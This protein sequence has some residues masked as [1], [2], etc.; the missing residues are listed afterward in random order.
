MKLH[1]RIIMLILV[2]ISLFLLKNTVCATE[3]TQKLYQDIKI[4][5]D[6]SITVKEAAV[7]SGE[8]NGRRRNIEFRNKYANKFS[9]IYSNFTGN[10]DIY[11]GSEIIN[12]KIGDISEENFKTIDDI[13]KI[14]KMYTEVTS[15]SSGAYGKYELTISDYGAN[16]KVYCPSTRN[17]VFYMEY[18]IKNA[19][20]V[21]NDIAE[22]YWNVMGSGYEEIIADFQVL[23]HLPEEDKDVRIWTHGPLSG[24]NA[25]VDKKTLNFKDRNVDPYQA[26]TV[27]IMFNKK[28]VPLATKKSGVN[29]KENI[30]K[31]EASQADQANAQREKNKLEKINTASSYV[32][33]LKESPSM[34]AYNRALENVKNLPS[35]IDEKDDLLN[36]IY[37]LK[38]VV[39]TK[40][41]NSI[42]SRISYLDINDSYST[43]SRDIK[44]IEKEIGYGFDEEYKKNYN[45]QLETY[46]NELTRKEKKIRTA[47]TFGAIMLGIIGI[48]ICGKDLIKKIKYKNAFGQKYYRDFPTDDAPYV[49][50]Y[51]IKGKITNLS[52]SAT[53]L[54]LI[55]RNIIK[56]EEVLN[57]K[58]KKDV[59]LILV[60]EN[61]SG[62]NA[63]NEILKLLFKKVGKSGKCN[64]N[65]LKNY[66]KKSESKARSII[67]SIDNFRDETIKESKSKEYFEKSKGKVLKIFYLIIMFIYM[68][69][70]TPSVSLG[71]ANSGR[72]NII[73]V[74]IC[75]FIFI[76]LLFITLTFKKRTPN[77]ALEYS[78]WMAHKR[79]LKDFSK[80]DEKE[81]PEVKLWEKY[82]VTATVLGCADKVQEAMKLKIANINEYD[83]NLF[84]DMYLISNMNHNLTRTI[85]R[86]V[87][88]SI[89]TA[90]STI[91]AESSSSSSG[92][93]GG[94]SSFGGG[95]GGR[96]RWRRPFLS[97]LFTNF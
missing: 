75:L 58:N 96:W 19:V 14:E 2:V 57:S 39:N 21:H 91:Y 4:N 55:A 17:K 64:L 40:W 16:F 9:G 1:K 87:N 15:A 42:E 94:G 82:M 29:G 47:S 6:G 36:E 89:S 86:A 60:V 97:L 63:E 35:N 83:D 62:T 3:T 7:L 46:K 32:I 31:Y 10:T 8:Y 76:T 66:G 38:D 81:L 79:F 18:T 54:D 37:K 85:N 92:G 78:K 34:Y 41:K 27:R 56:I 12:I 13:S 80:F 51:L 68:M 23:I 49:I 74:L 65:E 59:V 84:M 43:L 95:G 24:V 28:L 61:Y 48:I 5:T 11:D 25:I 45:K 22:L 33:Q 20:V 26:E 73:Y 52:V 53:I 30:L 88:S 90:N 67:N 77:G 93:F 72:F 50:E 71:R 70:L 44:S 69:I